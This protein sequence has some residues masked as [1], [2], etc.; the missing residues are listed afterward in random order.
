MNKSDRE[1]IMKV[2]PS[3]IFIS[4]FATLIFGLVYG[5]VYI[6]VTEILILLVIIEKE[7]KWK[8]SKEKERGEEK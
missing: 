7:R 2:L 8:L 1:I 3:I 6:L 5:L 4:L